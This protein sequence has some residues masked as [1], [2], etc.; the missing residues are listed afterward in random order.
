MLVT[1]KYKDALGQVVR[2]LRESKGMTQEA[3]GQEA[4]YLKGASVSISRFENGLLRPGPKRFA[5][6]ASALGLTPE[7]LEARAVE[8]MAL[9]GVAVPRD[10]RETGDTAGTASDRAKTPPG[11]KELNARMR[12]VEGEVE[13]RTMAMAHLNE[14]Y[15]NQHVRARN[16]FFMKF[17]NIAERL[18]GAPHSEPTQLQKDDATDADAVV[19]E[20]LES[21]TNGVLHALSLGAGSVAGAASGGVAA[22]ATFLAAASFGTAST[23]AAISGLSGIAATNATLALLGGGTLA[24]GGAMVLAGIVAAPAAILFAGGLAWMVRRNRKQRQEFAA[25]LDRA[26]AQLAAARLGIEA[27][28]K[29]LQRAAETLEYI[30]THAGHALSRWEHQLVLGSMTW[31]S[32]DL[33]E[34]RRYQDFVKVAAAQVMI[35]EF[36][37]QRLLVA[38]GSDLDELLQLADQVLTQ[39]Q[40]AVKAHV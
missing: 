10:E 30:A 11:Q 35:V 32:L 36:N 1:Q 19:A 37:F 15:D 29:S 5:G 3:L 9:D 20:R 34:K 2:D 6:T 21:C 24:A 18:E 23:G 25:Q 33:V 7:E 22:Y 14:T 26:E 16:E 40:A 27:F 39:S 38:S 8:Q 13:Q 31:D 28:H 12:G 4:G 17:V